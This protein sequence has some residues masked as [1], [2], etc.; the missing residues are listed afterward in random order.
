MTRVKPTYTLNELAAAIGA[1][2]QGDDSCKIHNIAP[3]SHA[4]AGEISF[5]ADRKYQKYLTRTQASAILLNKKLAAICPVNAL[6]M[7]NPKLGFIKLLALLRPKSLPPVGIHPTA[8][9]GKNC[10]IQ[11]T[12]SI[13]PYVVIAANVAIGERTVIATG[14]NIGHDSQVGA[15][16]CLYSRVTL[17]HETILGDRNIIHSGTV[18]GADGFGLMRD[19]G[20][21]QWIGIPQVGK[22]VIGDDV[23]IGANTTIDRGALDDT[24]IGNGVKIDNLVMVG[25]NVRIGNHTAIAGCAG[26]AGSTTI[27]RHCMIGASAGLNGHITIC[28]NV[29]ITGMGMIQKSITKPGIYSSGTGMQTNRE[30]RK[31]VVRFWQ[32]DELAKRLKRLEKF[33]Q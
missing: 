18:I 10:Q 2:V 13:G 15:D 25:H 33:L 32:L 9:I 1:I 30:W 16:C 20:R 22:V 14:T 21:R 24:I 11:P 29:I 5:L 26:I 12:V 17:Y 3:I 6:V 8:I 4:K 23:E 27:G 28:D 31:S 7:Q 19:E